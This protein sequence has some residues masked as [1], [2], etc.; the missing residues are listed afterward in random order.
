MLLYS[1]HG[2][3]GR[4]EPLQYVGSLHRVP[5]I[6]HLRNEDEEHKV[7]RV[8]KDWISNGTKGINERLGVCQADGA[9]RNGIHAGPNHPDE[10]GNEDREGGGDAEPG[11]PVESAWKAA[12]GDWDGKDAGVEHQAEA[13]VR[14]GSE[15]EF[16]RD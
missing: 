11:E 7:T 15:R 2:I 14:E 4:R 1:E 5:R 6:P 12:D 8:C 3:E 9:A 16:A 10:T 13:T